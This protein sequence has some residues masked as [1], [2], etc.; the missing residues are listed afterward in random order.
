MRHHDGLAAAAEGLG[1]ADHGVFLN[2][3]GQV[4]LGDGD[5]GDAHRVAHDDDAV[6][7]VDDDLGRGVDA[8][9]QVLDLADEAGHA[10][11]LGRADGDHGA[12]LGEGAVGI[13]LVDGGGDALGR[14][15][16]GVAQGQ[17]H[18]GHGRQVEAGL[19]LDHAARGDAA[20]GRHAA[21]HRGAGT[22][23]GRDGAG[24]NRALR[25]RIDLAVSA[26]QGRD[27]KRAA[28]QA[29]GVAHGR[30]GDVQARA[31]RGEGRQVG[32]DHDRR[33]VLG[34]QVGAADVDALALHHPF[35]RLAGEGGVA[36]AVARAVQADHQAVA[37]QLVGADA[38]DRDDVLDTRLGLGGVRRRRQNQ[39]GGS[40]GDE[41]G[42]QLLH[43]TDVLLRRSRLTMRSSCR[44]KNLLGS[45]T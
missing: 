5:G 8:D 34:V 11:G 32:G 39:G 10:H 18:D 36:K 7:L 40:G 35:Q 25:H 27:Q 19:A 29:L 22:A 44:Y 15:E 17:A 6:D 45:M 13:G 37:D 4:A 43:T 3:D 42:E 20:G 14:G 16:V 21:R 9:R 33:D 41:G 28:Q 2:R 38:L 1:L 12:V 26:L 24:L 31:R 23:R 30:D